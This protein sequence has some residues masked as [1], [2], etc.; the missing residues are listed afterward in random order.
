M[1]LGLISKASG[2][3]LVAAG[4]GSVLLFPLTALTLMRERSAGPVALEP[5]PLG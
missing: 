5:E 2:A 1:E 4:L 3:A